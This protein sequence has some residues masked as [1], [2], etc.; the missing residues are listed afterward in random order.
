MREVGEVAAHEQT[1]ALGI[2]Q[3]LGGRHTVAP[4]LSLDGERVR[5]ASPPP[6]HG[7]HS[8]EVLREAGYA[9]EEIDALVAAG[10]VAAP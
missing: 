5:F 9:D 4:P 3:E 6:L 2:L 7:E 10:V 1:R 8:R